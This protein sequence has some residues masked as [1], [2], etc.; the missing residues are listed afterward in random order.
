MTNHEYMY[1]FF[2]SCS[3]FRHYVLQCCH[4]YNKTVHE[5]LDLAI[6]KDVYNEMQKG[7]CNEVRK[8]S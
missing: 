1:G 3:D 4:D 2:K 8:Q 5:V 6:T 7:G